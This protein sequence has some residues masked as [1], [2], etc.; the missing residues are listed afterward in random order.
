MNG[1]V[2]FNMIN[3]NNHFSIHDKILDYL[4]FDDLFNL[5]KVSKLWYNS[6]SW[7]T[8]PYQWGKIIF[9]QMCNLDM[10]NVIDNINY[11]ENML[12]SK[13]SKC[14]WFN[15]YKFYNQNFLLMTCDYNKS[16]FI[17]KIIPLIAEKCYYF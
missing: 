10:L 8:N 4:W 9:Y 13:Y 15:D 5:C 6:T 1:F 12:Y 11:N 16:K 14:E 2:Q 17:H 3:P 7:N